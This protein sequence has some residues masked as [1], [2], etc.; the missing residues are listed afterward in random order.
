MEPTLHDGDRLLVRYGSRPH[1]GDLVLVRLPGG[2][3]GPRPLAVKRLTR[4]E[5]DGSWWVES[6][7]LGVGTDSWTVGAL[8][9][10]QLVGRVVIPVPRRPWWPRR[11]GRDR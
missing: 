2:P 1:T 4:V 5:Q 9:P 3:D 10:D 8:A 7:N 11:A 6:D